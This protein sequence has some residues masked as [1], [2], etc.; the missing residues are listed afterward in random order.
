MPKK[1]KAPVDTIS[2]IAKNGFIGYVEE[3]EEETH[4]ADEPGVIWVDIDNIEDNPYQH[5]EDIN[6]DEFQALVESI[7]AD[8]FLGALNVSP[9]A[10]E[11]HYYLNGGGHQR[12]NAARTAGL[13][14]LPVFVTEEPVDRSVLAFRVAR[15]NTTRVNTSII[16]LGNLYQQMIDEFKLT[17]DEIA[18]RIGKDRNHVKFALMA[19]RSASDIQDMLRQRPESLRAMTYFRRIEK[20]EDRQPIM[21][22]FLAGELS[23]EGVRQAVEALLESRKPQEKTSHHEEY[24]SQVPTSTLLPT[25]STSTPESFSDFPSSPQ[26]PMQQSQGEQRALQPEHV[27]A[28]ASVMSP[29]LQ[30]GET[31]PIIDDGDGGD[32]EQ[33][34]RE[35]DDVLVATIKEHVNAM[36]AEMSPAMGRI[37]RNRWEQIFTQLIARLRFSE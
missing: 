6:P 26:E 30:E 11:G 31:M 18:Q 27:S 9:L 37:Y 13:K 15:E 32:M 23:T 14:K 24:M 28:P 36:V 33:R 29:V 8:G 3:E 22:R 1:G 4:R 2:E 17:Q 35:A 21:Q 5:A 19:A 7:R 12:R 20:A 10:A 16:N 34:F 25:H